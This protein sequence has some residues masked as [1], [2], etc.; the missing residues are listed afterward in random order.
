MN[1]SFLKVLSRLV[2]VLLLSTFCFVL[3]GSEAALAQPIGKLTVDVKTG[4]VLFASTSDDIHLYIGGQDFYLDNP[5]KDDFERNHTDRFELPPKDQWFGYDIIDKIG[6]L[7]IAKTED[8]FW[9]GGWNLEGIT[10]WAGDAAGV[11]IYKNNNINKWLDGDDLEWNTTLKS[12]P[13][14]NLPE[15]K[16]FPPCLSG[17]ID[18]GLKTDSDCDGIPDENDPTFDTPKDSDGDSLPDKYEQQKGLNPNNPDEDGDGW[19]DG[20]NRRYIL[21]LNKIEC[22]DEEED[23]GRDELYLVAED[24]R[25]PED[26]TLL[27]SWEL[28]EGMKTSPYL[29]V[30]SRTEGGKVP[31][32]PSPKFKTR[33]RLRESDFTVFEHPYDDT[34]KTLELSWGKDETLTQ[35]IKGNDWHYVLTFQSHTLSFS[36]P[37]PKKADGDVD[38]DGLIEQLEYQIASQ[39][40]QLRPG[41][42]ASNDGYDGL[43]DPQRRDLFL[44]LDTVGAENAFPYD[45]KQMVVSRFDYNGISLRIDEGHLGGGQTLP[46]DKLVTLDDLK[47]TYK[48]NNFWPQRTSHFRYALSVNETSGAGKYGNGD[49]PGKNFVIAIQT[50]W[51][52]FSPIVFMHEFG[53]NLGLCHRGG[54]KGKTVSATCPTPAGWQWPQC[55]NYCGVGQE[56]TT[57]MGS[58]SDVTLQ[59]VLIGVGLV[60]GSLVG[61]LLG[62]SLG[63]WTGAL[64]GVKFGGWVGGIIGGVIGGLLGTWFALNL[65]DIYGRAVDYDPQEWKALLLWTP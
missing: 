33:L 26:P 35:T 64:I 25:F 13:N 16:P 11:P 38:E 17:N 22:I 9:G 56:S 10:I 34:F 2:G 60:G 18:S 19:W 47:N 44:E 37:S 28:D 43:A 50:L 54:D 41:N 4:D 30:D 3:C 24:V 12:D 61:I 1:Q 32:S 40:P 7:T 51:G 59:G 20:G 46:D 45:G 55:T 57:C 36:D 27:G 15:P 29:V 8:S 53:H 65:T 48:P 6:T 58:D 14:W 5:D 62:V 23:I 52:E 39:S 21:V 42:I 49:L 63:A 31:G